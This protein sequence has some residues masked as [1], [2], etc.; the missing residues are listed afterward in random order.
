MCGVVHRYY[1]IIYL[2]FNTFCYSIFLEPVIA[3]RHIESDAWKYGY[4]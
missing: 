2:I 3:R 1:Y 4:A